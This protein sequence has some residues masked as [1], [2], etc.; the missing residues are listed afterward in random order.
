MS[1]K[2][3]VDRRFGNS[4]NFQRV[5]ELYEDGVLQKRKRYY[6]YDQA[7]VLREYKDAG[8][9]EAFAHSDVQRLREN[10]FRFSQN[11]VLRPEQKERETVMYC[12][13]CATTMITK[14]EVGSRR[15]YCYNCGSMFVETYDAEA[16]HQ[17]SWKFIQTT[18]NNSIREYLQLEEDI[19]KEK[20]ERGTEWVNNAI[21]KCLGLDD[22]N[23]E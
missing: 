11:E 8:Y 21:R 14:G 19:E 18:G 16:I 4:N 3:Y 17:R 5:V 10:Y 22:V 12:P 1:K 23:N 13:K 15:C 20:A 9:E 2:Q 7:E 6:E